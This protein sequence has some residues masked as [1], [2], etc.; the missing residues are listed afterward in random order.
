M[1]LCTSDSKSILK[2]IAKE[3]PSYVFVSLMSQYTPKFARYSP[4][5][6]LQRTVTTFEYESVSKVAI[7][8]GFDGFFQS[9]DSATADYT[10]D[11]L[12]Y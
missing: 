12:G 10:P 5:R 9:K 7:S 11:F 2:W 4:D 3:L 1:P 8:L 6:N